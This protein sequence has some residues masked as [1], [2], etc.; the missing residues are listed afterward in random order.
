MEIDFSIPKSHEMRVRLDKIKF[1][2]GLLS[3]SRKV[4]GKIDQKLC[5]ITSKLFSQIIFQIFKTN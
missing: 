1:K 2:K 5:K 4:T 3:K